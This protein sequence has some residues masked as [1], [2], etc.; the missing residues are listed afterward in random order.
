MKSVAT[1]IALN[2]R[3]SFVVV[4][5]CMPVPVCGLVDHMT[6]QIIA[7]AWVFYSP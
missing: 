6:F 2:P 7:H 3:T 4:S 1:S 5:F